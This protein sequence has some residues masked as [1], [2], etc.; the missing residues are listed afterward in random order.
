MENTENANCAKQI[1]CL[2][3]QHSRTASSN[4]S[5][6]FLCY[7]LKMPTVSALLHLNKAITTLTSKIMLTAVSTI[8]IQCY[9]KSD[10][11][12]YLPKN[13]DE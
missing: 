5:T 9:S 11:T 13:A 7:V 2:P 10:A 8:G 3:M 1:V 6:T 4:H 12:H